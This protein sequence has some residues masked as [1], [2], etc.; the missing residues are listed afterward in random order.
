M[1]I[2]YKSMVST[3]MTYC[4]P[5]KLQEKTQLV[6]HS[7]NCQ[8]S[9]ALRV[10]RAEHVLVRVAF[11]HAYRGDLSFWLTSPAGTV[12]PLLL[13][14]P[15]DS[16]AEFTDFTFLTRMSWDENPWGEWILEVSFGVKM[17]WI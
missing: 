1:D 15:L 3:F 4:R 10:D 16:K 7:D 5:L 14:R 12:S 17:E 8:D 6:F 9:P 2:I 11:Q 13:N